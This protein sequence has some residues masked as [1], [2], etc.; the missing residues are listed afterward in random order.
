MPHH[1]AVLTPRSLITSAAKCSTD[2]TRS[3]VVTYTV[4]ATNTG[5]VPICSDATFTVALDGVLDD[6][7]YNGDAA[8]TT[9][10]VG[11]AGTVLTWTGDPD[12]GRTA[13]ITYSVT[14]DNPRTG[15][16]QLTRPSTSTDLGQH[17][18]RPAAR[19]PCTHVG[20]R[21]GPADRQR[22]RRRHDPA[23]RGRA[24]TPAR[25]P[26]PGR[27]PYVG[28]SISDSFVGALDDA[29]LQR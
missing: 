18:S 11:Y 12:L 26:T 15:D 23:D 16:H 10:T 3:D 17:L 24:A 2:G 19:T 21:R 22:R 7:T 1:R 25:S 13:T 4:T 29:T 8:A 5:Q 28:I 20:A 6:A 14:V 27:S 9:G